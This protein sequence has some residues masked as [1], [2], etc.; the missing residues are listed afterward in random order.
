MLGGEFENCFCSEVAIG[1]NK[2]GYR[3]IPG[4]CEGL[5]EDLEKSEKSLCM[6]KVPL[7]SGVK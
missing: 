1:V 3:E 4:A 2:D 7:A 5:K 6:A